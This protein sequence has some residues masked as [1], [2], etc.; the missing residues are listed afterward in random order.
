MG[1][2]VGEGKKSLALTVKYQSENRTLTDEEVNNMH[3][4][5]IGVLEERLNARIR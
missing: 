1:K 3:K 4:K 5:V 2:Q